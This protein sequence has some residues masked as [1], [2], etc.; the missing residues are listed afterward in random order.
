MERKITIV[1]TDSMKDTIPD[2]TGT[3]VKWMHYNHPEIEVEIP[4]NAKKALLRN[5]SLIM[6]I[7]SLALDMSLPNYL[8]L[9]LE[10]AKFKFQGS[11][12]GDKNIISLHV[13]Y[14]DKSSGVEKEFSFEGTE[15]ALEKSVETFSINEFM[16]E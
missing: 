7:V 4:N 2:V 12:E 11:L 6:P 14:R 8:A 3:F 13:K 16:K 10:F 5:Q 15:S 9:V 1:K